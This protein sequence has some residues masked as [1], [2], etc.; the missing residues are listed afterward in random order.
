MDFDIKLF[1][2][3]KKRKRLSVDT[4]KTTKKKKRVSLDI[5]K[6]ALNR[7]VSGRYFLFV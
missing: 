3:L 4:E 5:A 6:K 1:S 7:S 2:V